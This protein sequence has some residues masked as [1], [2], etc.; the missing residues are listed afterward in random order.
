MMSTAI[1][2]IPPGT[3]VLIADEVKGVIISVTIRPAMGD[4]FAIRYECEWWDG[5]DT[6]EGFFCDFQVKPAGDVRSLQIG[7]LPGSSN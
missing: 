4:D 5:R 1:N 2:V 7:F 6:K 3:A